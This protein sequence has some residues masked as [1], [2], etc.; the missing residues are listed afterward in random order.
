[1]LLTLDGFGRLQKLDTLA[2][3]PNKLLIRSAE[4]IADFQPFLHWDVAI[5][6]KL[7]SQ[8]HYRHPVA[9]WRQC[10]QLWSG[11]R[12]PLMIIQQDSIKAVL[13]RF[14]KSM[15]N[16]HEN[17]FDYSST[18]ALTYHDGRVRILFHY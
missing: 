13:I 10:V 15:D 16:S 4:A 11:L 6:F 7:N 3:A 8:Q 2:E 1:M 5:K 17:S 9:L 18:D 12:K 14:V